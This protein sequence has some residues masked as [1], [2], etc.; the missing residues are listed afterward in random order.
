MVCFV[1]SII[2]ESYNVF[3]YH[4]THGPLMQVTVIP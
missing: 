3:K 2:F 1:K 4:A